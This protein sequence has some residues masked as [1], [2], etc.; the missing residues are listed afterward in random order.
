MAGNTFKHKLS[1]STSGHSATLR[2]PAAYDVI[3]LQIH[4]TGTPAA[5]DML[6]I[7]GIDD[8]GDLVMLP[9]GGD[10]TGKFLLNADKVLQ[11]SW[12]GPAIKFTYTEVD[13]TSCLVKV[14]TFMEGAGDV[15]TGSAYPTA[16]AATGSNPSRSLRGN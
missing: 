4:N 1:F 10:S 12:K 6:A 9:G 8:D 7:E 15:D 11:F 3:Q 5:G 2:L 14:K 16:L 13:L